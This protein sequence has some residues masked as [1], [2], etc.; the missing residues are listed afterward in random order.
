MHEEQLQFDEA[1]NSIGL[2]GQSSGENNNFPDSIPNLLLL[3]NYASLAI[4]EL[5]P[6]RSSPPPLSFPSLNIAIPAFT[7]FVLLWGTLAKATERPSTVSSYSSTHSSNLNAFL[8]QFC[9][10]IAGSG[11]YF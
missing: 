1:A 6:I 7:R 11:I 10:N 2:R 4:S 8:I 5:A 3:S 9:P